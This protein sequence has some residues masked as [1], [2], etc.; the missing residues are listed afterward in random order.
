MES[1][2]YGK[3]RATTHVDARGEWVVPLINGLTLVSVAGMGLGALV[4]AFAFL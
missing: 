4:L 3:L 2:D 1:D